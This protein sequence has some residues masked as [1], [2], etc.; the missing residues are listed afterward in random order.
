MATVTKKKAA[1][2]RN[3]AKKAASASP[4][5]VD[6]I[7]SKVGEKV[8]D[9]RRA[10]GLSLQQ[11]AEVSDVSPAAIHKI[12]RS[13]MV[14]TI[15]T[16]L[17]LATAL[18]VTVGYF[19]EEDAAAPEPVH[20]TAAD[21]RENVYTPHKGLKLA[22]I[23]GPYRQFQTA[24]ALA[25]MAP[26][27]TSGQKILSHSGEELVHVT[28]GEVLF[29]LNGHEYILKEGDSLHFN[30]NVPHHWENKSKSP[31]QLIWVVFRDAE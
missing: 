24:A 9:L 12:E 30:G 7:I 20:F 10:K 29:R 14:P 23:T 25:R 4:R 1:P 3:V 11:L 16:L 6:D 8:S 17:K 5:G 21:K 15:T 27:A 2:R 18:G 22:G 19:V 31:A 13:G 26:G 28:S